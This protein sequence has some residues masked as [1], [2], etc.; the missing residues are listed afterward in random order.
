MDYRIDLLLVSALKIKWYSQACFP[1]AGH[2]HM[3]LILF[4]GV[5]DHDCCPVKTQCA[6]ADRTEKTVTLDPDAPFQ[7]KI[8]F[9]TALSVPCGAS[10]VSSRLFSSLIEF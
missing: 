8:S 6:P 9:T 1:R 5:K 7:K 2:T 3:T 4:E 10:V